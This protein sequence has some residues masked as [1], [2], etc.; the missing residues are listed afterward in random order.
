MV[1]QYY[2]V[3]FIGE[4]DQTE[5]LRCQAYTVPLSPGFAKVGEGDIIKRFSPP[6]QMVGTRLLK[7]NA[8]GSRRVLVYAEMY[9]SYT[10]VFLLFALDGC[11]GK[12]LLEILVP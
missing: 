7:T 11:L 6:R 9:P 8:P 5:C 1:R 3:D 12:V 10:Q 2:L 4:R